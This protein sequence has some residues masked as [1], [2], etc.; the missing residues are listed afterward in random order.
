MFAELKIIIE[1]EREEKLKALNRDV[2]GN[3]FIFCGYSDEGR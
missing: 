2:L 1:Y 3:A